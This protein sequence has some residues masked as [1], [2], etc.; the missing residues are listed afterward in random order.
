MRKS[1]AREKFPSLIEAWIKDAR[2]ESEHLS[3]ARFSSFYNWLK[4]NYPAYTSFRSTMGS[5]E[6]LELWFDEATGQLWKR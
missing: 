5:R 2:I 3:D 6:D 1:E 4:E